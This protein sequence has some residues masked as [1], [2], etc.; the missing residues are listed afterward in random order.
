MLG[1]GEECGVVTRPNGLEVSIE[2]LLDLCGDPNSL[3]N[4]DSC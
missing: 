4:W 3:P 2:L 1:C